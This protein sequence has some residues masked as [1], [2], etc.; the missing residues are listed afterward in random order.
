VQQEKQKFPRTV[1][2]DGMQIDISEE[3]PEKARWQM[4]RSSDPGSNFI[5]DIE[6]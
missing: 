4:R 1:T 5:D 3:H 2:V 6:V